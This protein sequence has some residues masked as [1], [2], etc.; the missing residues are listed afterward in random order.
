M[1]NFTLGRKDLD[2]KNS[3]MPIIKTLAEND[4][5]YLRFVGQLNTLAEK[6]AEYVPE[7]SEQNLDKFVEM[8]NAY[9]AAEIK[10]PDQNPCL[11]L[12]TYR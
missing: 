8:T 9:I 7:K 5:E 2:T 10:I 1:I 3:R 4:G 6:F 11:V 12:I